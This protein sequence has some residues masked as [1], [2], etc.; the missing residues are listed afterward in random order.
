VPSF[1][2]PEFKGIVV[3]KGVVMVVLGILG[4]RRWSCHQVAKKGRGWLAM[5]DQVR[6]LES[7]SPK[8]YAKV[9]SQEG[10]LI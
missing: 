10:L 2:G 6:D 3:P 8:I 1:H 9:V 5:L 4:K 7:I